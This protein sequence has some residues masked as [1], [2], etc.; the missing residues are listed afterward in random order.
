MFRLNFKLATKLV[1]SVVGTAPNA[2]IPTGALANSAG[3]P[4]L[5]VT[6]NY[7]LTTGV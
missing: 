5:D 2:T 7:I 4:I 3:Q 6:G 1:R